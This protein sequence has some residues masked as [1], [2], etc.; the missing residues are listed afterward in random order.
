MATT[1]KTTKMANAK[2]D[3]LFETIARETMFIETLAT[4]KSSGDFHQTAVWVVREAL[5]RAY[6]AGL[7][8]GSKH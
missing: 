3:A 6:D 7:A 2:L 8:A 5:Q 1:T 4:T